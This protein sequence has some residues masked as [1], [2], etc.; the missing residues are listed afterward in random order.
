MVMEQTPVVA[1]QVAMERTPAMVT[2][3][4]HLDTEPVSMMMERQPSNQRERHLSDQEDLV[5]SLDPDPVF[6]YL[7]QHGVLDQA[8][9]D[10]ICGEQELVERNI[11]LLKHL[12]GS[13][14]LAVELF[15]NALRQS[16]QMHLAS[17]LDVE[18]RIKP[19]YGQGLYR[20]SFHYEV[21]H[22]QKVQCPILD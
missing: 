3:D 1:R 21:L 16:G 22:V 6:D 8:T 12:E 7:L 18:H 5:H 9:I 19:V 2:G 11:R 10:E 20:F 4:K 13:G 15:I 14:N 17:S